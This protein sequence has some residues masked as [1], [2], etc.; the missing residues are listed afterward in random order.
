MSVTENVTGRKEYDEIDWDSM[1][2]E[3]E[4]TKTSMRKL[5]EKYGSYAMQIS[6]EAKEKKWVKYDPDLNT[7]IVSVR[8]AKHRIEQPRHPI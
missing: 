6:R 4:N 8:A 2:W 5:G 3:Y 7:T 1:R